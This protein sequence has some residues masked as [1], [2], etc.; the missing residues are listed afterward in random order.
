MLKGAVP[1]VVAV[2]I[3]VVVVVG[4]VT[5]V[6]AELFTPLVG[7]VEIEFFIDKVLPGLESMLASSSEDFIPSSI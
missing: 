2:H 6:E 3:L 5:P 7:R 1:P 4:A